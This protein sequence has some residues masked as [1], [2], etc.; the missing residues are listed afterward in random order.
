MD[1]P[2]AS[3]FPSGCLGGSLLK[4]FQVGL[5]EVVDKRKPEARLSLLNSGADYGSV[6]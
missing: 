3:G 4:M 1:S 5:N 2:G 6:R